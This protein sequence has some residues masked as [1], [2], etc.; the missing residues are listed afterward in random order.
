MKDM[1]IV[2]G[3]PEMARPLVVGTDTVFVHTDIEPVTEDQNGN[4]VENEFQYHEIQYDKDE[5]IQLMAEQ[6]AQN[7]SLMGIILGVTE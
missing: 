6:T 7:N 3:S 2:R 4:P 1:G 5:Y